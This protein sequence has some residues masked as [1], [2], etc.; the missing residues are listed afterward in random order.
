M[1]RVTVSKAA[2]TL[3]A[4][5]RMVNRGQSFEVVRNGVP[6]ARLVPIDKTHGD[7]YALAHALRSTVLTSEAR[8]GWAGAV[9][10]GR[11]S[12]KPFTNPWG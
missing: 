7:T 9:A 1:K 12:L 2:K 3:S 11:K 10:K 5:L 8:S 6:C 4:C